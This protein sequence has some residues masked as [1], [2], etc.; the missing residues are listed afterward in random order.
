MR[1]SH[2]VD[3]KTGLGLTNRVQVTIIAKNA[4][5]SDALAKAVSLMET[6]AAMNLVDSIPGT[7]AFIL[8]KHD[9]ETKAAASRHWPLPAP[10]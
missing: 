1:Y 7:S 2:I 3:P 5:S 8:S 9:N 10:K 6:K 4:T